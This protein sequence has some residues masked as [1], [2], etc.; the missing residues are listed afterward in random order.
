MADIVKSSWTDDEVLKLKSMYAEGLDTR[1]IAT[2]LGRTRRSI[3]GKACCLGL[4]HQARE[5]YL[6]SSEEVTR[7]IVFLLCCYEIP[8]NIKIIE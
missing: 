5:D 3:W 1:C 2:K 8:T 6:Y 7:L 4:S